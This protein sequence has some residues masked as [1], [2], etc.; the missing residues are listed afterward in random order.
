MSKRSLPN[1]KPRLS[2]EL[3]RNLYRL[4]YLSMQNRAK[5]AEGQQAD[6]GQGQGTGTDEAAQ[7]ARRFGEAVRAAG[8]GPATAEKATRLRDAPPEKA[9][10]WARGYHGSGTPWQIYRG[11]A[12]A[13]AT[14]AAYATGAAAA[15]LER[16]GRH[17]S[18]VYVTARDMC[19][20]VR[21]A[22]KYGPDN[23]D[24]RLRHYAAA[25]LLILAN[26]GQE[27][28]HDFTAWDAISFV[29]ETRS[30]FMRPTVI[31]TPEGATAAL[32]RYEGV[33][34]RTRTREV[35]AAIRAG[36]CGWIEEPSERADAQLASNVI[37]F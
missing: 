23:R 36:L 27:E 12:D 13:T 20:D 16:K 4:R 3:A 31:T 32:R 17:L 6:N 2:P 14:A 30:E 10:A 18:A 29:L 24:E 5:E 33:T 28:P 1:A 8:F 19:G 21:A 15:T 26:L 7:E 11:P 25:P 37:E 22:N 34:T 35:Q 9:D